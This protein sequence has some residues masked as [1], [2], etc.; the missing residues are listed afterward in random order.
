K[1]P[2]ASHIRQVTFFFLLCMSVMVFVYLAK[3]S[4]LKNFMIQKQSCQYQSFFG[5]SIT[6]C[7]RSSLLSGHSDSTSIVTEI[8]EKRQNTGKDG[9]E[10]IDQNHLRKSGKGD[11]KT[12][13][14]ET[15]VSNPRY[16]IGKE[17]QH[18]PEKL[19]SSPGTRMKN[20]FGQDTDTNRFLF[21]KYLGRLGNIM[22]IYASC[23][24]LARDNNLSL[25]LSKTDKIYQ[26][27]ANIPAATPP[28]VTLCRRTIVSFNQTRPRYFE[29][30]RL[31][32]TNASCV[33]IEG[34]LQSWKHFKDHFDDIRYQ[35]TW[36]TSFREKAIHK[37]ERLKKQTWPN[38]PSSK[39][40]TVGIHVRRGDYVTEKRPMADREY[41]EYA[42][43]YFLKIFSNVLFIVTTSPNERDQMWCINNIQNGSGLTVLASS[44]D[45]F[46]DLALLSLTDH[47]IIST[48]T[49]G[50]WAGFLNKGHVF[51][52]DWI[53][54]NHSRYN[55][56]DY[57]LPHWIGIK[58]INTDENNT[59]VY[60]TVTSS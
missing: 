14:K 13:S 41:F 30:F 36:R 5:N 19:T 22:F 31:S 60:R 15:V 28:N 7:F 26:P 45:S 58:A 37:I 16:V 21:P 11:D 6:P 44:N 52:F 12:V 43:R 50:W 3:E 20:H 53:P 51:Y 46:V 40:T 17:D 59:T 24:S 42:K 1:V 2:M 27:F 23:Y 35:F 9:P 54:M 8:K 39:I 29:Q 38:V 57:I 4:A 18:F 32:E 33:R 47:V 10:R 55:R 48:G 56:K 25:F 34:F 49:F